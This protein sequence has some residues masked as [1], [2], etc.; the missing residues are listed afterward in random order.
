MTARSSDD[1][2]DIMVVYQS[3]YWSQDY[4]DKCVWVRPYLEFTGDVKHNDMMVKRFE[5]VE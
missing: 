5:F 1:P 2:N 4:G 3:M